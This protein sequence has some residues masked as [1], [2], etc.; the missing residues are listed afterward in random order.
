M[1]E[2]SLVSSAAELKTAITMLQKLLIESEFKSCLAKSGAN[3]D[4]DQ[5]KKIN[6]ALQF[7]S[8]VLEGLDDNQQIELDLAD[9]GANPNNTDDKSA[10]NT[11][12]NNIVNSFQDF[13]QI[14]NPV[15]D[16]EN[17]NTHDVDNDAITTAGNNFAPP[18]DELK[19]IYKKIPTI[20][21]RIEE[22][23]GEDFD[24]INKWNNELELL[25]KASMK[26]LLQMAEYDSK[27][28]QNF[29]DFA[30]KM[31]DLI[32]N[33]ENITKENIGD[34]QDNF[35]FMIQEFADFDHVQQDIINKF[36]KF[37]G[38][39]DYMRNHFF[40]MFELLSRLM[41]SIIAGNNLVQKAT[42]T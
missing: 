3:L 27:A 22:E 17:L 6:A 5:F 39:H 1:T 4:D 12:E 18:L 14:E 25:G 13:D 42:N 29:D 36:T 11:N 23:L 34:L 19:E 38:S 15:M 37:L 26:L 40:N 41:E 10:L 21:H 30:V 28:K 16:G 33:N 2:P 35:Y 32:D 7:S 20:V 31:S 9:D 8:A 24:N